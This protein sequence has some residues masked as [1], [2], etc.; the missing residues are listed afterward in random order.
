M[1][2]SLEVI[3]DNRLY[4]TLGIRLTERD[5]NSVTSEMRPPPPVCWPEANQPHGGI[6][7]TQLDTTMATAAMT[8]PHLGYECSTIDLS[9]QY[10]APAV[11]PVF[12]C[13]ATVSRRGR[14]IAFIRGETRDQHGEVVAMGQGTFRLFAPRPEV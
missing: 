7:F 12:Y 8:G 1:D 2:Q 5:D 9:V 14:K 13:L 4:H 10:L 6:V 3:N 11:G